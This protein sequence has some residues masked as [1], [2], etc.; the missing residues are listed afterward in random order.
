MFDSAWRLERD[1]FFSPKMN[2]VD[3]HAVRDAYAKL[4]PL[5]GS[6]E[7]LNYLIGEILGEISNSHTYVG[8]GDEV[9]EEQSDRPLL[10]VDYGARWRL[11]PLPLGAHLPRRQHPRCV[12]LATH[13]AGTRRARR[14]LPARH[15]RGELRAPDDPY[16][17]LVGKQ[18]RTVRLSVA[19]S[20]D[21]KGRD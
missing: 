18:D 6:R 15:R 17:L 2:G 5:L 9:P 11:G 13:A 4:L 14:R 1:F 16:S 7:D 10:G 12:P 8:G 21:G 20:A 19:E 3:W